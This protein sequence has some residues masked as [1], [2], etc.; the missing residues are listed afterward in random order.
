[1]NYFKCMKCGDGVSSEL[2]NSWMRNGKNFS[3]SP[4]ICVECYKQVIFRKTNDD[5][6][7]WWNT[8]V[9]MVAKAYAKDNN[10]N[11]SKRTG[12]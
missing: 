7:K 3:V 5:T 6:D 11:R 8:Y 10:R 9:R 12:I 1:M 2:A 4:F